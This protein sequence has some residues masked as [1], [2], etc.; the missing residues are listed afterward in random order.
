MMAVAS[1]HY[2]NEDQMKNPTSALKTNLVYGV[3]A[4]IP[5]SS[6][7]FK[8][9]RPGFYRQSHPMGGGFGKIP[10]HQPKRHG[11]LMAF[12]GSVAILMN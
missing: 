3:I 1:V 9:Q 10:A 11:N 8:C 2:E 12:S 5:I 7:V 4:L 6:Y